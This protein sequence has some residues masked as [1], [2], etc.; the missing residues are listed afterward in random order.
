[1]VSP[2]SPGN[3]QDPREVADRMLGATDGVRGLTSHTR[4]GSVH[5]DDGKGGSQRGR[6]GKIARIGGQDRRGSESGTT[7]S[8]AVDSGWM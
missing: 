5:P 8:S 3:E 7:A 6:K 1:M 4:V 2:H